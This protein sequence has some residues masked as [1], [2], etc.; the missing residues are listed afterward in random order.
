MK[1]KFEYIALARFAMGWSTTYTSRVYV[2]SSPQGV[3]VQHSAQS[4]LVAILW[5]TCWMP[6][7][8]VA[9]DTGETTAF[10]DS[11]EALER[12]IAAF[13]PNP[14]FEGDPYALCTLHE[15]A[16]AV[17]EGSGGIGACLVHKG[18][19]EIIQ[20]GRN[21]VY[22]PHYR[23]DRHAEMDVLNKYEDRRGKGGDP[24]PPA[25]DLVLYTSLEPCPM[26]FSRILM[27]DIPT[28]YY[29]APDPFGGMTS[30]VETLPGRF[31]K[32]AEGRTFVQ[33][34]CSPELVELSVKLIL[35]SSMRE[36]D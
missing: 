13:V 34:A 27:T 22:T 6:G 35:L 5:L 16:K 11:L 21:Q 12:R 31:R 15:A 25:E 24:L 26:C 29:V 2:Y 9:Q 10:Q 14:A 30:K 28:V 8:S 18:T 36:R 4:V 7:R 1:P 33:L 20:G 3:R 32:M 23:S 19:G 17:G